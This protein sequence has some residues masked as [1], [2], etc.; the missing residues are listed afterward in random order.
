MIIALIL[1]ISTVLAANVCPTIHSIIG[2]RVM[3]VPSPDVSM[4]LTND[5]L[6][7]SVVLPYDPAQA[8][9]IG[10]IPFNHYRRSLE[11]PLAC[12]NHEADHL[13]SFSF[14]DWFTNP[15][16][17]VGLCD[18]N[19]IAYPSSDHAGI[20]S[21]VITDCTHVHY[22]VSI[23]L[24]SL[25]GVCGDI[26]PFVVARSDDIVTLSG[27]LFVN[28]LSAVNAEEVDA[29]IRRS[30]FITPFMVTDSISVRQNMAVSAPYG[31]TIHDP[32]VVFLD[33]HVELHFETKFPDDN[34]DLRLC[35]FHIAGENSGQLLAPSG[36]CDCSLLCTDSF[37]DGNDGEGCRQ[38]WIAQLP[39]L[40]GMGGIDDRFQASFHVQTCQEQW[41]SCEDPSDMVTITIDVS[42]SK[43]IIYSDTTPSNVPFVRATV[44]DGRLHLRAGVSDDR[45][46]LEEVSICPLVGGDQVTVSGCDSVAGTRVL[47]ANSQV[48]TEGSS[49]QLELSDDISMISF[50]PSI[51]SS[52][53]VVSFR[54]SGGGYGWIVLVS[55]ELESEGPWAPH[56]SWMEEEERSDL[57]CD[58]AIGDD[59]DDDDDDDS[60]DVGGSFSDTDEGDGESSTFSESFSRIEEAT[61]ETKLRNLAALLEPSSDGEDGA[62]IG[63]FEG[64]FI[65]QAIR[66]L[67]ERIRSMPVDTLEIDD[68]VKESAVLPMVL[69]QGTVEHDSN[70][71]KWITS[72]LPRLGCLGVSIPP[73][74]GSPTKYSLGDDMGYPAAIEFNLVSGQGPFDTCRVLLSARCARIPAGMHTTGTSTNALK[75]ARKALEA[76][77]HPLSPYLDSAEGS[78]ILFFIPDPR[79]SPDHPALRNALLPLRKAFSSLC[80]HGP[81]CEEPLHQVAVLVSLYVDP[82]TVHR[83][84]DDMELLDLASTPEFRDSTTRP[85]IPFVPAY[86]SL[87]ACVSIIQETLRCA[88]HRS[89]LRVLEPMLLVQVQTGSDTVGPVFSVLGQ[90]EA[91]ILDDV[92]YGASLARL[93]ASVPVRYGLVLAS[94]L[95]HSSR[96]MAHASLS[97][98]G[99]TEAPEDPRHVGVA[100]SDAEQEEWGEKGRHVES[101][102]GGKSGSG[103]DPT[104]IDLV[105]HTS[106]SGGTNLAARL[107]DQVRSQKGLNIQ[108][109]VAFAEKQR[110]L[111]KSR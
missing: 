69:Q 46:V 5:V 83:C 15:S 89:S 111:S 86:P 72:D 23:P 81:L 87:V 44:S 68:Q 56:I 79:T 106:T 48:T 65:A 53:F 95:R 91:N 64:E 16:D 57:A 99:W 54:T 105:S 34:P 84:E 10:F 107:V 35:N 12:E 40:P 76:S 103:R 14:E 97:F 33:G 52:M 61:M 42:G 77:E 78:N 90:M 32:R 104:F 22:E 80:Q 19:S 51:T 66:E 50:L 109:G 41:D 63:E 58:L 8:L 11:E 27:Q 59:D 1:V 45:V 39:S 24:D 2:N 67:E 60:S 55:Q 73:E 102:G 7:I 9:Y 75:T 47:L 94:R 38:N 31:I 25:A 21:R 20:W 70:L 93:S 88:L 49:R 101:G 6:S 4:S 17:S 3:P 85:R 13:A 37:C 29:G 96:G 71:K 98:W 28:Y 110:T 26:D 74:L 62:G 108:R 18:V 82:C 30:E 100:A 92:A 43:A 36:A